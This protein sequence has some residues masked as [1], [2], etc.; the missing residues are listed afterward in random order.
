M[1]YGSNSINASYGLKFKILGQKSL[2]M[3]FCLIFISYDNITSLNV[4]LYNSSVNKKLILCYILNTILCVFAHF[5][6]EY[7]SLKATAESLCL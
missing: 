1:M 2:C 4:I 6:K 5:F 7:I 3:S